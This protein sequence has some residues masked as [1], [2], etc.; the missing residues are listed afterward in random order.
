MK[1]MDETDDLEAKE[2]PKCHG[3]LIKQEVDEGWFCENCDKPHEK[4]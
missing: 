4:N 1:A 3:L 2:C